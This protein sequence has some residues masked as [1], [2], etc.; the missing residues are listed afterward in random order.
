MGN[1]AD[2]REILKEYLFLMGEIGGNDFNHPFFM[3]WSIQKIRSFV[4]PV[5]HAMS[6]AIEVS[7]H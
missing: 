7:T 5:I 1:W 6:S 2:C 4:G 3:G